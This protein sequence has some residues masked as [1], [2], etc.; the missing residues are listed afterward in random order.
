M[1]LERLV[2]V[3]FDCANGLM[4]VARGW[5][6]CPCGR[7][8]VFRCGFPFFAEYEGQGLCML[9]GYMRPWCLA[10]GDMRMLPAR[11]R[12][13]AG[14]SKDEWIRHK[15]AGRGWFHDKRLHRNHTSTYGMHGHYGGWLFERN[16]R[17][18]RRRIRRIWRKR[19]RREARQWIEEQKY[20]YKPTG[21]QTSGISTATTHTAGRADAADARACRL[22]A[23]FVALESE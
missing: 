7:G 21:I 2:G 18:Q 20:E 3:L 12:Y 17:P 11:D 4:V 16:H 10:G 1:S 15:R 19:A 5:G 8:G 22:S 6:L 14:I 13:H 9:S 23:L